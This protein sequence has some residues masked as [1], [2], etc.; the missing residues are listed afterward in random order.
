M[1]IFRQQDDESHVSHWT[2][3]KKTLMHEYAITVRNFF[4]RLNMDLLNMLGE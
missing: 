2:E 1:D 4:D 3:M